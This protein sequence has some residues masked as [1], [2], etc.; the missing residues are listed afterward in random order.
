[1]T[2]NLGGRIDPRALA[3]I[4]RRE[5]PDVLALQELGP[6]QALAI[7]S[8]G[9]YAHGET[10]PRPGTEGNGLLSRNPAELRR[11]PLPGRDAW[12]ARV[13]IL[14]P[15]DAPAGGEAGAVRPA[16]RADPTAPGPAASTLEVIAVHLTPPHHLPPWRMVRQR[17]AQVFA[18]REYLASAPDGP[19]VL[20][21]DLNSTPIWP[22][23]R[24]L[25]ARLADAAILVAS[26]DGGRTVPTWGPRPG[27]PRLFRIDHALISPHVRVESLR[28]LDLPGSDHA[29]LV[30]DIA[31][32]ALRP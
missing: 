30:A 8:T 27:W 19:R 28:V 32:P 10:D 11:F 3:A 1:M 26:L 14:R 13:Q 23:Y 15:A 18:L 4:L 25:S 2:A 12:I 20:L 22:A 7:E 29:A 16:P 9:L 24:A 6:E 21:G 5:A 17:R 31:L